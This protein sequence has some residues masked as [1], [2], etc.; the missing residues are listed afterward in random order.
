MRCRNLR[1]SAPKKRPRGHGFLSFNTN[2]GKASDLAQ[3]PSRLARRLLPLA[4]WIAGQALVLSK[5]DEIPHHRVLRGATHHRLIL[6]GKGR[7][8]ASLGQTFEFS[9]CQ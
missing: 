7:I 5:R 9:S 6:A 4:L 2:Y 3:A 1:K 8:P